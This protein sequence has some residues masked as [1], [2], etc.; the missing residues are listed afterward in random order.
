MC[1]AER[2]PPPPPELRLDSELPR[3]HAAV[4][5]GADNLAKLFS[6]IILFATHIVI[7]NIVIFTNLSVSLSGG[8]KISLT[9]LH[10]YNY[11][12]LHCDY[13]S[14]QLSD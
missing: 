3:V 2:P 9:Y 6:T 4:K 12:L 8:S 10:Q 1:R 5:A 7:H 14:L 11:T 13:D